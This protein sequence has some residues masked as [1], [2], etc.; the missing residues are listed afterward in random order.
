MKENMHRLIVILGTGQKQMRKDRYDKTRYFFEN[1][2]G[3]TV[4]TTFIS[5]AIIRLSKEKFDHVH[6]LGTKDSMWDGLYERC[7]QE[8]LNERTE[9]NWNKINSGIKS[10]T[11]ENNSEELRIVEDAFEKEFGV[12]VSCQIINVGVDSNEMW[13]I[14]N[15]I[16]NIPS[17]NDKIS[18]DITHGLRYQGMLLTIAINYFSLIKDVELINVFYGAFELNK[19]YD[20]KTPIFN[21]GL[22]GKMF[23]WIN[24]GYSFKIYGDVKPLANLFPKDE[25]SKEFIDR[26]N[27][28]SNILSLNSGEDIQ[29]GSNKFL[30]KIELIDTNL[31]QNKP[32]KYIK[33][34]IKEFPQSLLG[35]P[36]WEALLLIAEHQYK[37]SQFGLSILTAWE[38]VVERFADA[39]SINV[40]EKDSI[41]KP[42]DKHVKIS[43]FA[44]GNREIGTVVTKL[45]DYR[46]RV[47]H[48]SSEKAPETKNI[49]D[50]Y[51]NIFCEIKEK[52]YSI[53]LNY[54]KS[55]SNDI[56]N[57]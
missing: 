35:K 4:E 1:N 32:F 19:E 2:P 40:R 21:L 17:E 29:K 16:S 37:N 34:S 9:N 3:E 53:D 31:P 25:K 46:N 36:V 11:L 26:A 23:D 52:L 50:N 33:D 41:G 24:A 14:F 56:K 6:I 48:T 15:S 57:I 49:I 7:I 30:K 27:Y 51:Y 20:G 45:S 55:K 22:I 38:A 13:S 8:N 54:M 5:D 12:N 18:I 28:F 39:A 44:R 43:N 47:A 42:L 10:R